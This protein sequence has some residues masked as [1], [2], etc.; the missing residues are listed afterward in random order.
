M[1]PQTLFLQLELQVQYLRLKPQMLVLVA[2]LHLRMMTIIRPASVRFE[3]RV[4]LA[5][6]FKQ[7]M[8]LV[9][10]TRQGNQP[11]IWLSHKM[12]ADRG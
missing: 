1:K 12:T 2:A 8:A 4:T 3:P 11:R 7:R 9:C 10:N 5:D 6:P